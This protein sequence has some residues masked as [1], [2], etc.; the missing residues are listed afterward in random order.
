MDPQSIGIPPYQAPAEPSPTS[1][2]MTPQASNTTVAGVD[3]VMTPVS[4]SAHSEIGDSDTERASPSLPN[5][6][7]PQTTPKSKIPIPIPIELEK[8]VRTLIDL[9]VDV[10]KEIVKE[11]G[12]PSFQS[13]GT[14]S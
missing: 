8:E 1:I 6:P 3:E 7:S 9:P 14:S 10:L 4:S 13:V 2:P 11:V 5:S 12:T